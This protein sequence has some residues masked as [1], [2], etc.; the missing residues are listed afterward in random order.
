METIEWIQAL[1]GEQWRAL[2]V[3]ITYLGS[4]YAYIILFTLYYWLID[5]ITGRQLGL[6]T[7]FGFVFNA[8]LKDWFDSPRPFEFNPDIASSV[9]QA[10]AEGSSSFPSGHSQ[11]SATF[12]LFIAGYYRRL[13]LWIFSLT[14][15]FLVALSR[16]YLGVH[17]PVDVVAGVLIGIALAVVGLRWFV[18]HKPWLWVKTTILLLALIIAITVPHFAHPLGVMVGFLFTAVQFSVP[19]TGKDRL[20]FGG[21]GLLLVLLFHIGVSW[22]LGDWS[23]LRAVA[24]LRYLAVTLLATEVWPRL[25]RS[26]E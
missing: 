11:G 16:I 15:V 25:G 20:F 4:E 8:I 18:S 9:A 13:W 7:S 2:F 23:D 5:P 12:W 22:L 24:F 21:V 26:K 1:L 6:V 19:S 3:F 10:S 14:I 17:F